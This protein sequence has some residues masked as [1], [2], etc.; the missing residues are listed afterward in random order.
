ML[1]YLSKKIQAPIIVMKKVPSNFKAPYPKK[2]VLP[3]SSRFTKIK[4]ELQYI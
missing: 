1:A 4:M 2:R 3:I